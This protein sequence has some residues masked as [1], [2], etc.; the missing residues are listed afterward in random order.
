[1]LKTPIKIRNLQRKLYRRAKQKSAYKFYTLYD[2]VYRIDILTHAYKLIK[3]NGGTS[4]I[5][6]VSLHI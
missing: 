5:D 3:S 1:M 4:G 6:G 2:K